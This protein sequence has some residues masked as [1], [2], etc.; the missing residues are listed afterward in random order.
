MIKIELDTER[1]GERKK[2]EERKGRRERKTKREGKRDE[3]PEKVIMI[4]NFLFFFNSKDE[5]YVFFVAFKQQQMQDHRHYKM[6]FDSR[7]KLQAK[8]SP[9]G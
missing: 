6:W 3:T 4:D 2:D 9:D 8:Q 5:F 1:G 7:L